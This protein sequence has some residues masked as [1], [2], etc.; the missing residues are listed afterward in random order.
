MPA[1]ETAMEGGPVSTVSG[2]S[3]PWAFGPDE[4]FTGST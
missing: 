4:A 2:F 1:L 3:S